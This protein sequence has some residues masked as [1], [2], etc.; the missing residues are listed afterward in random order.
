MRF[1]PFNRSLDHVFD[2]GSCYMLPCDAVST[3]FY[4]KGEQCAAQVTSKHYMISPLF[5]F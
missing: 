2:D 5:K 4:T 1:L 3:K